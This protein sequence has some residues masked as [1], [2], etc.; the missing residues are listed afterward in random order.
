MSIDTATLGTIVTAI[1]GLGLAACALVDTFKAL[2]GGGVSNIGF[3]SIK[4]AI[5]LFLPNASDQPNTP[6][7]VGSILDTLRANWINGMAAVD[8]KAVAK[9]LIKLRLS[10]DTSK[11]YATVTEVDPGVLEEVARRMTTGLALDAAH[12][13]VL[14][15]FDL[16]LTALL[17]AAYQRADQRYRNVSKTLAAVVAVILAG[18]GGGAVADLSSQYS[19]TVQIL[20]ALFCGILA[21]PLAPITKDLTSALTA[22][23]KLAQSLKR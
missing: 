21:V 15:R 19:V 4:T 23:V 20:L 2:P 11:Q 8:Q 12:T 1:G 22:G 10:P 18:L 3:N 5:K 9:S 14:G 13:N 6:N 17:D 16:A 7:L